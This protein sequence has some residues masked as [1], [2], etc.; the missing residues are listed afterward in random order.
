MNSPHPRA[1]RGRPQ[2]S[3]VTTTQRGMQWPADRFRCPHCGNTTGF[4]V[5][6][7]WMRLRLAAGSLQA[8]CGLTAVSPQVRQV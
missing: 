8:H 6:P 4:N 1:E 5:H 7:L 2:G 3:G